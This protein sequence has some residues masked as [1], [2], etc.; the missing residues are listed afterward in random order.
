MK[1]VDNKY[2][3]NNKKIVVVPYKIVAASSTGS[4]II[5]VSF[6]LNFLCTKILRVTFNN[7]IIIII[8]RI[9]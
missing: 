9:A 6:R 2:D 4:R 5:R 3:N 8:V 1:R 7:V